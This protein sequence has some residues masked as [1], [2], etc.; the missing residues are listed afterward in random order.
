MCEYKKNNKNKV[1]RNI[2]KPIQFFLHRIMNE[3][4]RG[5]RDWANEGGIKGEEGTGEAQQ[6]QLY[7]SG[8]TPVS[9]DV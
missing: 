7:V 8:P 9:G 6:Y 5:G 4:S 3:W 2:Y 1:K